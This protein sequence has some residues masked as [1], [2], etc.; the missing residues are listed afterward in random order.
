MKLMDEAVG[1]PVGGLDA[2]QE[3]VWRVDEGGVLGYSVRIG[4]ERYRPS[5]SKGDRGMVLLERA[6]ARCALVVRAAAPDRTISGGRG[7]VAISVVENVE[8]TASGSV[9]WTAVKKSAW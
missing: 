2:P 6:P 7:V 3:W 1:L 4:T 8:W 9:S 5:V